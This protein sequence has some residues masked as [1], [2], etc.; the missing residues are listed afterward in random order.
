M[1]NACFRNCHLF[2]FCS[3]IAVVLLEKEREREREKERE[4]E[5]HTLIVSHTYEIL[6]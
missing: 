5:T 6:I 1:G 4:R 2:F 3:D